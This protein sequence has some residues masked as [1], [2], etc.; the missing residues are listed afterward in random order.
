[1]RPSE[2]SSVEDRDTKARAKLERLGLWREG[3]HWKTWYREAAEHVEEAG[4]AP[5]A[6]AR[7]KHVVDFVF[8]RAV[9]D[10]I[11]S[12]VRV[13]EQ[14]VAANE[15]NSTKMAAL[16]DRL[17]GLTRVALFAAFVS[18]LATLG[19]AYLAVTAL[20]QPPA[21]PQVLVQPVLPF[22]AAPVPAATPA[23]RPA[24]ADEASRKAGGSKPKAAAP[25]RRP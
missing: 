15:D 5:V 7:A 4:T 3:D 14:L 9:D 10:A 13:T 19:G 2:N 22:P 24:E 1:M 23:A 25:K 18:A 6:P 16:A 17:S 8:A 11:D 12:L 21:P 20:R